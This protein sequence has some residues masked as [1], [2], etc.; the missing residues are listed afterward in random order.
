MHHAGKTPAFDTSGVLRLIEQH[1]RGRVIA[2]AEQHLPEPVRPL[3]HIRIAEILA[4][5]R[6]FR[7]FR[8]HRHG[9]ADIDAVV[10]DGRHLPFPVRR[11][12]VLA[13]GIIDAEPAIREVDGRAREDAPDLGVVG[14]QFRPRQQEDGLMGPVDAIG[15]H[16][17]APVHGVP[18]QAVRI[19]LV[20]ELRQATGLREPVRVVHPAEGRREM[21]A[22]ARRVRP[23]ALRRIERP[24]ALLRDGGRIEGVDQRNRRIPLVEGERRRPSGKARRDAAGEIIRGGTGK[25]LLRAVGSGQRHGRG[26]RIAR[27]LLE[28]VQRLPGIELKIDLHDGRIPGGSAFDGR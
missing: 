11:P 6:Q 15:R 27:R 8:H 9:G 16:R 10:R 13:V 23:V 17:M 28:D 20:E 12:V 14:Q 21:Q 24:D 3:E 19:V 4:E 1:Q 18:A 7:H 22:V 26:R 5:T 25:A 2:G